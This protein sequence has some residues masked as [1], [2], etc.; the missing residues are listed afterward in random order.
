MLC[1]PGQIANP[2]LFSRGITHRRF[3]KVADRSTDQNVSCQKTS[4][5]TCRSGCG[6]LSDFGCA[7]SDGVAGA[8]ESLGLPS[9]FF[10]G[11]EEDPVKSSRPQQVTAEMVSLDGWTLQR[12]SSTK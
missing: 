12:K 2:S 7:T 10:C 9:A 4:K 3:A 8:V 6:A 11:F 1:P 5:P